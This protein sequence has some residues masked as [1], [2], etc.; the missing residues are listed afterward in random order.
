MTELFLRNWFFFLGFLIQHNSIFKL[1]ITFCL[2]DTLLD[3]IHFLKMCILWFLPLI[4]ILNRY[5]VISTTH[6]RILHK[7]LTLISGL[8]T[9]PSLGW[10]LLFWFI[11]I[12]PASIICFWV[13]T[14]IL[15][16]VIH[17]LKFN[18]NLFIEYLLISLLEL[19]IPYFFI[20]SPYR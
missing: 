18:F 11:G 3:L 20:I 1:D 10:N 14:D 13:F 9:Q 17:R 2:I 19:F 4:V 16:D 8:Y 12:M 6:S 5:K 15:F 7:I